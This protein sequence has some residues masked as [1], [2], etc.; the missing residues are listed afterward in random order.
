MRTID[1]IFRP[2]SVAVVGASTSKGKLGWEILHNI[3][4]YEFNGKVFPVN[5][6]AE[7]IHSIKAYPSVEAIPDDVDLAI[8]VVPY[9][10]VPL[11]VEECGKKGVKGLVIITAGFKE[12]GGEGISRER[13]LIE[14]IE[15]YEMR[16]IGPNCMGV[17][18]A[19][20][21]V[22]L[23][24]TFIPFQPIPGEVAYMSQSGAL[25]MAVLSAAKRLNIGISQ[26]ASVGNKADISGNDLLGYW[27][28][29]P[30]TKL[31][32]MY[33]ESFGNPRLFTYLA[34][35]ISETKPIIVVKS[36]RTEAGARAATSHTGALAAPD[37][38]ID[39]L[40][41]QT[42]VVRAFS[43]DEMLHFMQAFVRCPLPEGNKVGV[44]TNAGGPGILAVDALIAHG[45]ELAE[46]RPE[47]KDLL[48]RYL[49]VEASV[50]NPIDMIASADAPDFQYGVKALLEDENVQI[51]LVIFVPP[52]MVKPMDILEQ[53]TT[54]KRQFDKT[55]VGVF[56]A[57]DEFYDEYPHLFPD[58]PPIYRYPETAARVLSA[59][60]RYSEWIRRPHGVEPAYEV[61]VRRAT[62]ILQAKAE[63]G[64]GYLDQ[65]DA[66]EVLRCYGLPVLPVER[67]QNEAELLAA[68]QELGYP[69]VLKVD[70]E[71]LVH[72]S[73]IGGVRLGINNE[74]E[75]SEA[76][77]EMKQD[78]EDQ[79]VLDKAEGFIVQPMVPD[80][81]EVILGV[82]QEPILG[83]LLMFGMGGKYVE[84]FQ[85]VTFRVLPVDSIDIQEMV[86]AVKGYALLEGVRGSPR[87]CIELLEE[88]IGRV[89][90]L[91]TDHHSILEMDINP[92]IL[93]PERKNCAVV[94]VRIRVQAEGEKT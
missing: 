3:I 24:A 38:A 21:D 49:P 46:L 18:N 30:N 9:T 87:V 10:K 93:A 23:N 80:G 53:V 62:E 2:S 65:D 71:Q 63:G 64:G 78:L 90:Q 55:V 74:N 27:D 31:I 32:A 72:K 50:T 28:E 86:R 39:A 83:P 84:V 29:D 14:L 8:I 48:K 92:F 33:L 1:A 54:I 88:S 42:G 70:G 17:F 81:Q 25:G 35:R 43:I 45:L 11:A 22:R 44:I 13:E 79:G 47:T 19:A 57:A 37:V 73:D 51:V 7:F 5:P 82:V 26:F 40:L 91:I 59:M 41:A 12:L 20:K 85:D 67:V 69:L 15:K 36:G 61:D 52:M 76:L 68:G 89:A 66:H 34:R 75:L 58:A 60:Y 16:L 4:D 94:D 6:K 77:V 56:M